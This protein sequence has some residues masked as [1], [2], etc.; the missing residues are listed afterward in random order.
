MET[1]EQINQIINSRN[2]IA[3]THLPREDVDLRE[4]NLL[5]AL[6]QKISLLEENR[7]EY[8]SI[9]QELL[10]SMEESKNA[11]FHINVDINNINTMI[12]QIRGYWVHLMNQQE[13]Y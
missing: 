11:L 8:E 1:I 6:G 12:T 7:K 3:I 2:N 4:Q 10:S 13:K 5:E 9:R